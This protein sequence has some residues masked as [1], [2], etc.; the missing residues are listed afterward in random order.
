M[1]DAPYLTPQQ[2]AKRWQLSHKT[3]EKWRY[4]GVGPQYTKVGKRLLYS[5]QDVVAFEEQ[6]RGSKASNRA[7][8]ASTASTMEA[9][10]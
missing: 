1:Q 8:P 9:L 6:G 5:L 3:L 2:L 4:Q 10:S 7:T